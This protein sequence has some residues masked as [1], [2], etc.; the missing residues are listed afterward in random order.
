MGGVMLLTD[1]QLHEIREIIRNHHTAF[2]ASVISP[3]A[4]APDVLERLKEMGLVDVKI[5]SIEDAYLYGQVL[6]ALDETKGMT[7]DQ[8]KSH[9]RKRPIPLTEIEKRAIDIS[10]LLDSAIELS[11]PRGRL[12]SRPMRIYAL[13]CV[14]R[15]ETPLRRI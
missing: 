1:A 12:F 13:R 15:L 9:V 3:D 8:F 2:V 14:T 4:V 5:S 10:T 7:Y 11:R 6:A